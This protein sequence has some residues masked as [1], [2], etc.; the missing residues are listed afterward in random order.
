MTQAET[1]G[2]RPPGHASLARLRLA[3]SASLFNKSAGRPHQLSV[4]QAVPQGLC[5]ACSPGCEKECSQESTRDF[6]GKVYPKFPGTRP[7]ALETTGPAAGLNPAG[8]PGSPCSTPSGYLTSPARL[9]LATPCALGTAIS[10]SYKHRGQGTERLS[11]WPE[12]PQQSPASIPRSLAPEE[13]RVPA[14]WYLTC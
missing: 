12:V 8:H 14:L 4:S 7:W 5:L 6:H 13:A 3:A 11:V 10:S 1:A 9:S 2:E